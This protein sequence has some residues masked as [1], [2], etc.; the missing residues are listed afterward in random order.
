[1]TCSDGIMQDPGIS[2]HEPNGSYKPY[3]LGL[4]TNVFVKNSSGG[5]LVGRVWPD[6][7]VY[8]D[9]FHP[10]ASLYWEKQIQ[11]FHDNVSFDGLWI[12]MNEP[13]NFVN[14]SMDGCG[15]GSLD[16]P[17]YIPGQW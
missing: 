10:N 16:H 2:N 12:D 3:N 5:L 9:F 8:P 4:E 17:P 1:M 11:E 6:L 13:S 15:S 14:G 7:T